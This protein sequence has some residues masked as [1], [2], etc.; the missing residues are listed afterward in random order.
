MRALFVQGVT[1]SHPL[2]NPFSLGSLKMVKSTLNS[3]LV[4]VLKEDGA[5]KNSCG[6]RVRL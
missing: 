4:G 5:L 2:S 3:R 1:L 6:M